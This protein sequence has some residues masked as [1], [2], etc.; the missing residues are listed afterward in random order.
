M[1]DRW[2]HT[3]KS[4]PCVLCGN[5][6]GWCSVDADND[7]YITCKNCESAPIGWRMLKTTKDGGGV[8]SC[9]DRQ[10]SKPYVPIVEPDIIQSA[11]HETRN[12]VYRELLKDVGLSSLSRLDLKQRG[13]S[14]RQIEFGIKEFWWGEWLGSNQDRGVL[15]ELGVPGVNPVTGHLVYGAGMF[16]PAIRAEWGEII[17][18]QFYPKEWMEY[19][20]CLAGAHKPPDSLPKYLWIS[21]SHLGGVTARAYDTNEVPLFLREASGRSIDNVTAINLCEGALKSGVAALKSWAP[22]NTRDPWLGAAGGQFS[23]G[24]LNVVLARYPKLETIRLWP[25]AGS[26]ANPNVT[27]RYRNLYRTLRSLPN[28]DKFQLEVVDWGQ[29][30]DKNLDDPDEI[31]NYREVNFIPWMTS[32]F[33]MTQQQQIATTSVDYKVEDVFLATYITNHTTH[34]DRFKDITDRCFEKPEAQEI[35]RTIQIEEVLERSVDFTLLKS[36]FAASNDILLYLTTLEERTVLA[37]DLKSYA[38]EMTDRWGRRMVEEVVQQLTKSAEDRSVQLQDVCQKAI[39]QIQVVS[40]IGRTH[41]PTRLSTSIAETLADMAA[42][43]DGTTNVVVSTG[44]PALDRKL[45]GLRPGELIV[46]GARPGAGKSTLA[47][48]MAVNIAKSDYA[49]LLISLE[50]SIKNL[51]QKI[52]SSETKIWHRAIADGVDINQGHW[53]LLFNAI[54]TVEP[55]DLYLETSTVKSAADVEAMI[56]A[57]EMTCLKKCQVVIIDYLQLISMDSGRSESMNYAVG[58]ITR[59]LKSIALRRGISIVV[60]SQLSRGVEGRQ[61]KRPI[62]SDLRDSGSIE[63]DADKVVFLYRD[64]YYTKE[65]SEFPG[66]VEVDVAKNRNGETGAVRLRFNAA[67]STFNSY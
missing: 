32:Q 49:V 44:F 65:K 46:M 62:L 27:A 1:K 3:N 53:T 47:L 40:T 23:T 66:Q 33:G 45:N 5:T 16:L 56:E 42:L 22:G 38:A 14:D 31:D 21:S 54:E 26:A 63:Q 4:N 61:D 34:T 9:E 51:S 52:L 6:S 30:M 20:S 18:G 29:T 55:L 12:I 50:M 25:D 48:N 28:G 8:F 24:E 35:W 64:D 19:R 10:S 43:Q 67:T 57:T 11:T 58:K 60:L 37:P 41:T 17:G 59:E 7:N 36:R 39:D 2:I 13:L 15:P